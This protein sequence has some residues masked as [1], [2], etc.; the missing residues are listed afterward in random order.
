MSVF[1]VVAV[2][3]RNLERMISE[4]EAAAKVEGIGAWGRMW[5]ALALFLPVLEIHEEVEASLIDRESY[6]K[7]P[8]AV[9]LIALI[10][11]QHMGINAFQH[12]IRAFPLQPTR[13]S[14][15]RLR[16]LISKFGP[17]LRTHFRL[18]EERLWP[19]Y[20]KTMSR[21]IGRS[22]GHRIESEILDAEGILKKKCP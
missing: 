18:E 17:L 13:D 2:E 14:L 11:E 6:L 9:E 22:L 21:S 12:E 15:G 7:Q 10:E 16:H 1:S 5:G 20:V 19:H 8:G 4:L 3:H